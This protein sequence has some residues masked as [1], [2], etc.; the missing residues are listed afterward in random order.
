MPKKMEKQNSHKVSNFWFGFS[1][2][3][4]TIG[5]AAFLF[6]TKKGR[7]TLKKFLELSEN[8][9]ENALELEKYLERVIAENKDDIADELRKIPQH[10]GENL[11]KGHHTLDSLL[12][13]IKVLSP[14]KNSNPVKKFFKST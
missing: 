10:L 12:D 14:E 7:E 3:G 13:K 6:G 8:L 2:G 4:L 1:L 9:E 11:E 5:L